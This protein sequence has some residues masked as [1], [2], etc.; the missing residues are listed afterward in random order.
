LIEGRFLP[1]HVPTDRTSDT[2]VASL[3]RI[4]RGCYANCSIGP[5]KSAKIVSTIIPVKDLQLSRPEVPSPDKDP[6]R[7]IPQYRRMGLI[8]VPVNLAAHG[9]FPH[10][11]LVLDV[12]SF[13]RSSGALRPRSVSNEL[14]P[15]PRPRAP[16]ISGFTRIRF[17]EPNAAYRL[18]Q[19]TT[20][21]EHTH[22]VRSSPAL[23]AVRHRGA[24]MVLSPSSALPA[25]S[26]FLRKKSRW[27][28]NHRVYTHRFWQCVRDNSASRGTSSEGSVL[29]GRPSS[30]SSSSTFV[31]IDS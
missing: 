31:V 14:G 4:D 13:T 25:G 8:S 21:R 1:R 26:F 18:L 7:V 5:A 11:D 9:A 19:H 12:V 6:S 29:R 10:Y 22:K 2:S 24:E 15:R 27:G 20:T 30:K 28:A 16:S 3:T 17:S 23:K